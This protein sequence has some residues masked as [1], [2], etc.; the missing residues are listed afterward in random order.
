[1][2]VWL[3]TIGEPLPIDGNGGDRLF[4]AGIF[5]AKLAAAGH[6]VLW[7]TST[8]DHV[9]KQ[10]RFPVDKLLPLESGVQLKLIHGCGYSKNVS[11][12]RLFDHAI[13]GWKFARQSAQ[14][15]TPD[16]I[17]C[18]LPSLD[19]PVAVTR[20]GKLKG[21]PV[22]VDVR[23]LWPDI[24]LEIV[25]LWLRP[26][27]NLGLIF[28]WWQVRYACRNAFAITGNAP[29]FVQ[30]GLERG[31]R[32]R[33]KL[34]RYF[35]FGYSIPILTKIEEDCANQFWAKYALDK[36]EIQFTACF[37]GAFNNHFDLETIIDAALLLDAQGFNV[38][39]V[40]CGAGDNLN[41]LKIRANGS[42]AVIFPGWIGR[43]EIWTLMAMSDVGIAPYKNHV[44]FLGNLPNK[45][46]EYLA[47]GLPILSGLQGYLKELVEKNGC[48]LHYIPGKPQS[49]RN[50]I[51]Y[52]IHN[53]D[54][55]TQMSM[56]ARQLFAKKFSAEMVYSDM[57]SY[58]QNVV[59]VHSAQFNSQKK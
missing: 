18:S 45:P 54:R 51:V 3:V 41:V 38:R 43:A 19:L 55:L 25:P 14:M 40:L 32:L 49:L 13:L 35:P 59:A 24:F 53:S 27:L 11:L 36:D 50:A 46:I 42:R 22:I 28:M 29:Y 48:G 30:W 58:L 2:R 5:A 23:D 1:M 15:S 34:D 16:V 47:G 56:N 26:L 7:W 8:F 6:E 52:L 33:T 21:V 10:H 4:R 37:F 31:N 39:F 9:R 12:R 44:G 17:L 57:E 20:Y